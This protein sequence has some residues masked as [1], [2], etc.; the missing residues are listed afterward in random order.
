[1]TTIFWFRQDLRLSDNPAL[2]EAAKSAD[3][4]IPLYIL[5]DQ[6][7]MLGDAQRWWLHHSLSSL[8]TALSKKGTSL[9][10]K[11][12]DTKR[13]LLELIKKYKVEKIYWNRSYEPPYREIDTYLENR[14][15]PLS[16]EIYHSTLL[17][18]PQKIKNKSGGYYK[19]FTPF[20]KHINASLQPRKTL[21]AP[22]KFSQHR[23]IKSDNLETWNLLPK[24]PDWSQ[25][26]DQWK[27]GEKNAQIVLKK[28]IKEN[29]KNY[30]AHRDRPDI[31]STSHLSPYLHFGEISIR[32]VWTAI[33]QATIQDKNL[34]KAADV[35][36]RQLIWREFAYYLLWHF[37]QMGKSNFRNQFDNFKWKKNKN[38]L[39][40]WQK[41][42]TGYP[43]VDAGM[44]EL[45]CTGY[46]HN[47]ARM[48]VASFLVKDLMI[49]WREGEKWFWNTLLDA[50]LANNA[51]GWQWIAGCGLDAAPYFRIFNP[52]LQS[53]KFDPDGTYIKRWI[54]ELAKVPSKYIHY[55]ADMPD[56]ISESPLKLTSEWTTLSLS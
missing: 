3:H 47:R 14:L 11:K 5:D 16:V 28:F 41:G 36:L 20:W 19:I 56:N 15:P 4:L 24:H 8:Q 35:F 2:V 17:T 32:Q 31:S 27:P 1:M 37:P 30:P 43:I 6:L 53:K 46:M 50:D 38:W 49:D 7:K 29:L 33:T 42:L 54:P 51:L 44:R 18:E 34:Q 23:A 40:A 22:K 25:G 55:P 52:I 26:F 21:A 45:W 10:L 39:R 48:I 9:I 12:G 13:V